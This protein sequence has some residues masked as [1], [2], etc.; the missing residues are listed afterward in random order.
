MNHLASGCSY[1]GGGGG[2]GSGGGGAG[3]GSPSPVDGDGGGNPSFCCIP[4]AAGS[5]IT[6]L[7]CFC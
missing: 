2:G 5:K 7:S 4:A 1:I 3:G 6:K